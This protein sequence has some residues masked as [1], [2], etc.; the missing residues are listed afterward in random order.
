MKTN[1]FYLAVFA[2]F[3]F[4]AMP[5][6]AQD[7]AV[8]NLIGKQQNDVI[9]RY[10]NPVHKD[11]SSPSMVCFFYKINSMIFVADESGVF[12]AEVSKEYEA[13]KEA[14]LELSNLVKKA[15]S[16][17]F[18]SDT[19]SVNDISI[20]KAGVKADIHLLNL[21]EKAKYQVKIKAVRHD[22]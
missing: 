7:I 16:E 13:E 10:G 1:L 11:D 17:G 15:V 4:Y 18:E 12:Q 3:F 9:T 8:Y 6:S 2:I 20:H 14:Q 22:E 21:K 19:L 5:G